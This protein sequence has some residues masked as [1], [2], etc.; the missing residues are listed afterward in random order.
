MD[1]DYVSMYPEIHGEWKK[2]YVEAMEWAL[3]FLEKKGLT[4][5]F[6]CCPENA[7]MFPAYVK[8]IKTLGHQVGLHIHTIDKNTTSG[9]KKKIII[10][11]KG[12]LE[13]LSQQAIRW[14]RAGMFYLDKDIAS[15]LA[16]LEFT[17]DS[18]LVPDIHMEKWISGINETKHME[19]EMPMDYSGF[20]E[21][22]YYLLPSLL[23]VPPSR[24]CFDFRTPD[25]M[26]ESI[27]DDTNNL[28]VIYLHPK[29]LDE[30]VLKESM[31]GKMKAGL[32]TVV[33]RLTDGKF[34]FVEY[35]NIQDMG[36]FPERLDIY[37]K[38]Y[39]CE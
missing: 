22:P 16:E 28:S 11:G 4:I 14:F 38:L 1:W 20:P 6:F 15:I 37:E 33:D 19:F 12:M 18:S 32:V 39:H 27:K 3:E 35:D 2:A 34:R 21:M 10:D 13:D 8:K 23:E 25:T 5:T 29:N 30:M 24:Y 31:Q 36:A 26:I 17:G 7:A 9:D